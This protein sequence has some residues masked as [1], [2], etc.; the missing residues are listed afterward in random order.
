MMITVT[1]SPLVGLIIRSHCEIDSCPTHTCSKYVSLLL[2]YGTWLLL[3]A[4]AANT[5]P[6]LLRLWLIA[7][8][9]ALRWPSARLRSSLSLKSAKERESLNLFLC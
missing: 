3:A 2:R 6:M 5:S 4:S 9:S 1:R 8:A 7:H